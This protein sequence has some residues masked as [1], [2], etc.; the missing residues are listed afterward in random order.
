MPD[1]LKE[2]CG[3]RICLNTTRKRYYDEHS[4]LAQRFHDRNRGS[5]TE[6]GYDS[7]WERVTT[8]I[9]LDGAENFHLLLAIVNWLGFHK[10]CSSTLCRV[11]Q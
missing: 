2:R 1:L 5:S 10:R 3:F 6:R 8:T 7:D 9:G 4:P 11:S